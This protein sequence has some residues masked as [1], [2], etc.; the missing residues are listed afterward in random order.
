VAENV[1]FD[2]VMDHVV[3]TLQNGNFGNVTDEEFAIFNT[4]EGILYD[5]S[6]VKE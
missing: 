6:K 1:I 2:D 3:Q 5:Q 4:P